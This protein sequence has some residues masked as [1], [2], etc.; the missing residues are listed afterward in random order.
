MDPV[1]L[2]QVTRRIL[3]LLDE[4]DLDS[5]KLKEGILKFW[6][7]VERKKRDKKYSKRIRKI[8]S[9]GKRPIKIVSEG[10]SWH[11]YPILLKEI[12]DYLNLEKSGKYYKYAIKSLGC[13]GDFL[14]S[15]IHDGEYART[16]RYHSP[17]YFL[18]SGICNDLLR[19][20]KLALFIKNNLPQHRTEHCE[21]LTEDFEELLEAY[22]DLYRLILDDLTTKYPDM[23]IL[24][25]GYDYAIP[26]NKIKCKHPI[27]KII[28][29]FS[30]PNG[31]WL[32]DPLQ[33]MGYTD[34]EQQREIIRCF[35]NKLNDMLSS[36]Q[37]EYPDNFIHIDLRGEKDEKT[38]KRPGV[39][40]PDRWFDEIHPNRKAFR[41]IAK[42][43]SEVI[44]REEAKKRRKSNHP[45]LS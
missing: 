19:N 31:Q 27:R 38:G 4:D 17:D 40:G 7:G 36:L 32:L 22:K 34:E 30:M 41:D 44:M 33:I 8:R 39:V 2:E 42:R 9:D 23:K 24:S 12:I 18:L 21:N 11:Q 28:L 1:R 29:N 26:T 37:K 16:I 20:G 25:H 14:I 3:D 13:A 5:V 43:F 15:M 45:S 6:S 10:D 35:I